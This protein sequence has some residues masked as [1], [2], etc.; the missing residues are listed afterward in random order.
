[1]II[2]LMPTFSMTCIGY[3]C[4]KQTYNYVKTNT[5]GNENQLTEQ[6]KMLL[7]IPLN[8]L[9]SSLL[10]FLPFFIIPLV[11][12]FGDVSDLARFHGYVI[13]FCFIQ[14]SRITIILTC[15]LKANKV[16]QVEMSREQAREERRKWENENSFKAKKTKSNIALSEK[17][18]ST[19]KVEHSDSINKDKRQILDPSLLKMIM[20]N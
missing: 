18:P 11:R 10:S 2:L 13:I 15:L 9:K 12:F 14:G 19:N 5:F 16:N 7:H 6:Q 8:A 17:K 4:D 20:D 3:L 1:M